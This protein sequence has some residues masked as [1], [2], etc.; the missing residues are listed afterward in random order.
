MATPPVSNR[1]VVEEGTSPSQAP[2]DQPIVTAG[3]R[4][5]MSSVLSIVDSFRQS[6][7]ATSTDIV[8]R[9]SQRSR[10][11]SMNGP[12]LGQGHGNDPIELHQISAGGGARRSHSTGSAERLGEDILEAENIQ[13]QPD[14][15]S[16]NRRT[17]LIS[18]DTAAPQLTGHDYSRALKPTSY[19]VAH[20]V[21][22]EAAGKFVASFLSF[23]ITKS[24]TEDFVGGLLDQYWPELTPAERAAWL[25]LATA[26]ALAV[27]HFTAEMVVRPALLSLMGASINATDPKL[28][29]PDAADPAQQDAVEL[30]RKRLVDLQNATKVGRLVPDLIGSLA[31]GAAHGIRALF[32]A[33]GGSVLARSATSGSAAALMSMGHTA[34][35]L[36]TMTPD[37]HRTHYVGTP[38]DAMT[39]VKTSVNGVL[40]ATTAEGVRTEGRAW[41]ARNL[42][43]DVLGVRGSASLVGLM[44]ANETQVALSSK[45]GSPATGSAAYGKGHLTLAALVAGFFP[46]LSL[47]AR[48]A[49]TDDVM[50]G[51]LGALAQMPPDKH[52]GSVAKLLGLREGSFEK[53][54]ADVAEGLYHSVRITSTLP[55]HVALDIVNLLTTPFHPEVPR[56]PVQDVENAEVLVDG[57]DP[58]QE[59]RPSSD[60]VDLSDDTGGGGPSRIFVVGDESD[61]EEAATRSPL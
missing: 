14:R 61:D 12:I 25:A 42:V 16:L 51:T 3:S 18:T 55:A 21:A 58:A 19:E 30:D 17:S 38:S 5:S 43:Q 40:A 37:G 10:R 60:L 7:E 57:L 41:Q 52:P 54:V 2:S 20:M 33:A 39:V 59:P 27:A 36:R 24:L 50:S 46:N 22:A 32:G 49:K 35:A 45:G 34:L 4:G 26:P 23:G 8:R 56:L 48:R 15:D 29:Y 6:I 53:A 28:V 9:L 1:V 11:D 44:L 47:N 13:P 31:F